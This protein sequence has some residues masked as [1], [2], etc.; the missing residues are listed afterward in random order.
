MSTPRST[1]RT[2]S[3]VKC[4]EYLATLSADYVVNQYTISYRMEEKEAR[5]DLSI[6][7]V[8]TSL[9]WQELI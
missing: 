9:D 4:A 2:Q 5:T 8:R 1:L 7:I 6:T 3:H